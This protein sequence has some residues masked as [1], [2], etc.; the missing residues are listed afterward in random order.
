MPTTL[1][2]ET[3]IA[4]R[5]VRLPGWERQ[6]DGIAKTYK[7]PTYMAGLAFATAVGVIAEGLDHHPDLLIGWRK[8]T[9]RFTTHDAGNKLSHKDFAAAEAIEALPYKPGA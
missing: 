2:T 8:V 7:M 3:E 1:A 5:L 6:G 9:V 4:E